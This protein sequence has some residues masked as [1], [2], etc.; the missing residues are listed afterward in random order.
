MTNET[1]D[2]TGF[3]WAGRRRFRLTA[4]AAPVVLALAGCAAGA[5]LADLPPA[6]DEAYH[7]GPGDQVRI[8]TYDEPQLTNTFTVGEDGNIA[9]PLVGSIKAAGLTPAALGATITSSLT[10]SRLISQPSVSV[11]VAQY[12]PISVLGE[13]VHPGQYPYEPGMTMLDAVSLAGGFTYRAVTGYA[14]DWRGGGQP[15]EQ[16]V[17]GKIEPDTTLEPGDVVTIYERYF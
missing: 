7:L 3:I 13:V 4:L 5:D 14:A 17:Q 9:V 1:S 2:R 12:R 10:S 11:Q 16:A 15:G 8:I 6:A